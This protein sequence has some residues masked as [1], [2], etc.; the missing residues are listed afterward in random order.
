MLSSVASRRP[1]GGYKPAF[2]DGLIIALLA[3]IPLRRRKLSA[4]RI[5]KQLIKSGDAWSLD[6][7]AQDVKTKRP[8]DYPIS[9]ELSQR[10]D[11]YLNEIRPQIAG[12]GTHD[13][14]WASSRGG[15]LRGPLIY[16]AVRKRTRKALGFPG[17]E[18]ERMQLIGVL[19]GGPE[20][21]G[22]RRLGTCSRSWVGGKVTISEWNFAGA[23]LI[24]TG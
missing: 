20:H 7:P 13:Y 12:A 14:L 21:L 5:G 16:N 9:P 15:P 19:M 22:S 18:R 1:A 11:I 2:R 10:I 3:L 6:I 8:L 23:P 24:R 4:L 17:A